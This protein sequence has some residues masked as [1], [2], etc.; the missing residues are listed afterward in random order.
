M[1]NSLRTR[2]TIAFVALAVIPLLAVGTVLVGY[3]FTVQ[4]RQALELQRKIARRE[5]ADIT[6]FL[7]DRENEMRVMVSGSRALQR[8][9]S[10]EQLHQITA[11]FAYQDFYNEFTLIDSTG[12]ET[13]RISQLG[14][15][16]TS[17][18]TNRSGQ[19]EFEVPLTTGKVYFSPLK[20]DPITG[21]PFGTIAVPALN[22]GSEIEGVLVGEFR[23]RGIWELMVNAFVSGSGTVYVVDEHNVVVAHASPTVVLEKTRIDLP[24]ATSALTTGLSGDQVVLAHKKIAMGQQTLQVVTEQPVRE[25]LS[26]VRTTMLLMIAALVITVALASVLGILI[27]R[28]IAE[29][30]DAL[31]TTA[32][33]ISAGD[34]ARQAHVSGQDEI[35]TLARAFNEMTAQLRETLAGLEQRVLERTQGLL[36]A[37]EVSNATTA[38]L[39]IEVLLPQ[40]VELVRERF[41]LYYVGLFLVDAAGEN[42]VLRAGSGQA[43]RAM[44][45]RNHRLA[46]GGDSMIGRCVMTGEADIQLDVGEAAVHFDNPDLPET[47]SELALPLH[48]GGEVIGAMTVQSEKATYFTEEDVSVMQTVADQVA[49]AVRNAR[50][51]QQVQD[52]LEAE[53][54]A[55]GV[56]TRNAWVSFLRARPDLGF[57]SDGETTVIDAET[58]RPEMAGALNSGAP[59]SGEDGTTLAI[60]LRVRDQ[61][62]GVIDGR[63]PDGSAW[64]TEERDLLQ[65]LSD[66]LST[67]LESAQLYEETQRRAAREQAIAQV[68]GSVRQELYVEDVLRTAVDQVQQVLGLDKIVIQ[69]VPPQTLT[70]LDSL[71]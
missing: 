13:F 35:A 26:L 42:A 48:A 68:A 38:V 50:L 37:A 64:S 40:V 9:S 63:K 18:L 17:R 10:E 32:Q 43:G 67:A 29:P 62:V 1:R 53:R 59:T 56:M 49:N 55:Y 30:I 19:D 12:Q 70:A 15:Y 21:E 52:S 58:W 25:A 51:F 46:V 14:T 71:E 16:E 65:A 27:A 2:L 44:L 7:R 60:P 6:V 31:A 28:R 57:I 22:M 41:D 61:V 47:R 69:V 66:Q 33:A 34:L 8:I 11:M 45:A 39:D 23:F 54:R 3:S 5:A 20:F 24:E 36:T 4:R